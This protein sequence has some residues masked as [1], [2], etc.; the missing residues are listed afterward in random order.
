MA[1]LMSMTRTDQINN[2][3]NEVPELKDNPLAKFPLQQQ[4]WVAPEGTID[5][6]DP[7]FQPCDASRGV[8]RTNHVFGPGPCGKGYYHL[9]TQRSYQ[10]L[11]HRLRQQTKG[12]TCC[13]STEYDVPSPKIRERLDLALKIVKARAK[14]PQPREDALTENRVSGGIAAAALT[15]GA[16]MCL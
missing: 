2:A 13:G 11:M 12:T 4:Q 9:L 10:I 16:P 5:D 3:L 14:L 7:A 6:G 15:A 1:V 8:L